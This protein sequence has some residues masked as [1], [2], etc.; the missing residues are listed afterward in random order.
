MKNFDFD[1]QAKRLEKV[2]PDFPLEDLGR[3]LSRK[4]TI[5]GV[6]MPYTLEE[7]RPSYWVMAKFFTENGLTTRVLAEK[8]EDV[9]ETFV[10][11]V[12]DLTTRGHKLFATGYQNWL[13][14][15]ARRT[16]EKRAQFLE[17][18]D[19]KIMEKLI[20]DGH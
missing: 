10:V 14:A 15:L 8:I 12:G 4:R 2:G 7:L 6:V 16:P 1:A 11:R 17:A 18:E 19:T 3:A 9:D 5:A 13:D 20:Q